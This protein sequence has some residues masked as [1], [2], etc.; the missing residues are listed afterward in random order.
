MEYW[1]SVSENS[2]TSS[3]GLFEDNDGWSI[4]LMFLRTL[5]PAHSGCLRIMTAE[6]WVSVSE[7]SGTSSFGLFEDNDSG[8]LG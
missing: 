3:F 7:S 6:Y 8:V 2:G 4:G 5:V 1:V